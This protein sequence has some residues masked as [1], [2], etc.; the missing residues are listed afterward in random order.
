MCLSASGCRL[1][2]A[3]L[4]LADRLLSQLLEGV[5]ALVA[6]Q[7]GA[8]TSPT[9]LNKGHRLLLHHRLARTEVALG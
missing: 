3:S 1:W 2:K 4:P 6:N 5:S 9:Q 8:R 7:L